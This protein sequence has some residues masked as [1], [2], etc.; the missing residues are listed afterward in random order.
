MTNKMHYVV[1]SQ[2]FHQHVSAGIAA[3]YRVVLLDEY[4]GANV[5]NCVIV[6]P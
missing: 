2:F 1:Y 5:V 4:K 3:I 6:I